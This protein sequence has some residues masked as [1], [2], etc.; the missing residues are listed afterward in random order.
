MK[1][2]FKSLFF[3]LIFFFSSLS[4]SEDET[5]IDF[6]KSEYGE[7][8]SAGD[9]TTLIKTKNSFSLPLKNIPAERKIDFFVGNGF[10][11]R[12][13]VSSPASTT[14]SDGLGPLFNSK[15]CQSCH[16][17]D[18]RGH[19]PKSN[20]PDD[21]AVSM[22]F[23]LSVPPKNNNEKKL[24]E[25]VKLKSI[26][27]PIYGSQLRDF[28]IQG[29]H[30]EGKVFIEYEDRVVEFKNGMKVNLKKPIYSIINLNYG[31]L[32]PDIQISARVAQPM[33]GLGLIEAI[34]H[35]DILA[36]VDEKDLD[37]DGISGKLNIV[38]DYQKHEKTFGRF[39]WKATNPNI[40]QQSAD[41]F[42][43]DM[44][45]STTIFKEPDNCTKKQ[46]ICKSLPNGNSFKHNN[47]EV[48]NEQ[49]K[50]INYYASHLAVPKRRNVNKKEVLLGKKIF[51]NSGCA[52]CHT[53]KF[54]TGNHYSKALSNQVIFPYSDF[55]LHDMGV[56]L[57]DKVKE[58]QAEGHEWRT[59]PLWGLGLTKTVNGHTNLL[60]DGRARNILEAILWH[61]GE[62]EK[63]KQK[64]LNLSQEDLDN[65]LEFLNSL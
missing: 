11:K 52:S 31:D 41:A 34:K 57:A 53:Q 13:W 26:P 51:F 49:L 28:S 55:L 65:L 8:L 23:H 47:V 7:E 27:D 3:L 39:G 2:I 38:W 43:N 33:I 14:A 62:A 22:V 5:I 40:L 42:N 58:Y 4:I 18:G 15:T 32:Q 19:P 64:V 30:S 46:I 61:G 56:E 48:S 25:E 20:W 17:K 24:L 54:K 45:L 1:N 50:L 44:G 9:G 35:K 16:L 63:S 37:N 59:Q 21:T 29:I 60:H 12:I 36:N 6:S 10:F